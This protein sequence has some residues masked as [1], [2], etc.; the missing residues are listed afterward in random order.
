MEFLL[1]CLTRN[2]RILSPEYSIWN[3]FDRFYR[4]LIKICPCG[5]G[6]PDTSVRSDHGKYVA[7]LPPFSPLLA[8]ILFPSPPPSGFWF[9]I[10]VRACSVEEQRLTWTPTT[11]VRSSADPKVVRRYGFTDSIET[12]FCVFHWG[13]NV[14]VSLQSKAAAYIHTTVMCFRPTIT[15]TVLCNSCHFEYFT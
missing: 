2:E 11:R 5:T 6:F 12:K 15:D 10:S 13:P 9:V 3:Y 1:E 8:Y 4:N 7:W 14:M